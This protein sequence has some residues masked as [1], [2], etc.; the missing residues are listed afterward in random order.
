MYIYDFFKSINL[1]RE[2]KMPN[3]N[4]IPS[5]NV[6]Y[7]GIYKK[8]DLANYSLKLLP[9]KNYL[10]YSELNDVIKL[11]SFDIDTYLDYIHQ[12]NDEELDLN[13]YDSTKLSNS[14]TEAVWLLNIISSLEFNPLF[15]AQFSIPFS[16]L[17]DFLDRRVSDYLDVNEKFMAL[18][19]TRDIYFAQLL[20]F[21]KKYIKIKL[22]TGKEKRLNPIT[23][24]EF[25][26]LVRSKIKEFNDDID[27]Y[28]NSI[29]KFTNEEN[30]EFNNLVYQIELLG[31]RQLQANRDYN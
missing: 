7:F 13:D 10:I 23:Y 14:L 29:S 1:L 2:G 31:E 3:L 25:S 8:N 11:K 28:N 6:L 22:D 17:D 9:D 21:V 27:I 12:L 5:N 16:Y 15:D 18:T 19:L 4:E 24:E 30:I 26:E 20:Y